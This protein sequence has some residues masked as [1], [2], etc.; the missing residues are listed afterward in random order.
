ML[1]KYL[2]R[3][4]TGKAFSGQEGPLPAHG[5]QPAPKRSVAFETPLEYTGPKKMTDA[6]KRKLTDTQAGGTQHRQD[7]DRRIDGLHYSGPNTR[8]RR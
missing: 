3:P 8:N 4:Q 7:I 1:C 2:L 5:S 6:K